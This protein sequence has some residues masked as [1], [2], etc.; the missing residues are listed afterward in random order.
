MN[1]NKKCLVLFFRVDV[2]WT[3]SHKLVISH[4]RFQFSKIIKM[5]IERKYII[6]QLLII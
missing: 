4:A 6:A 3:F 2:R 5:I 1:K